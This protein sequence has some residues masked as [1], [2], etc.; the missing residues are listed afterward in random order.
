[1]SPRSS[2]RRCSN[3]PLY[4][5]EWGANSRNEIIWFGNDWA[6]STFTV[7][8]TTLL[9]V[10]RNF[11]KNAHLFR[12]SEN[13]FHLANIKF[14]TMSTKARH[15]ILSWAKSIQSTLICPLNY[16][17]IL[18]SHLC[19][20]LLSNLWLWVFRSVYHTSLFAHYICYSAYLFTEDRN[21]N[22]KTYLVAP[23]Y[24]RQYTIVGWYIRVYTP[25]IMKC[26]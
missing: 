7:I 11:L 9:H 15:W 18:S 16:L 26:K 10:K 25:L 20:G 1:M 3:C 17:S 13:S 22:F 4:N 5:A 8:L 23:C 19:L 24:S 14:I 2:Y 12:K 6:A 21:L